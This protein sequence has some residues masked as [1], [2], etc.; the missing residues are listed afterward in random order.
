MKHGLLAGAFVAMSA[1]SQA[2]EFDVIAHRGA[3][4]YLPEHT[5]EAA[6]LAHAQGPA[7]IEQDVVLTKD[8]IP[9]VLHDIHLE[10]VTNVESV[11]PGRAREDKRYYAIDFTLDELKQLL[12]HERANADGTQV[13]PNRYQGTASFNIATLEEHIELISQ[14]NRITGKDIGFY[15]EVKSPAWHRSEGQDISVIVLETLRKYGLDDAHANIYVQCF[16]HDEL[17]RIRNDLG[18]KLKLVQLMGENDWGESPTDYDWLRTSEG[19]TSIKDVAQGIGPWFPQLVDMQAFAK[20]KLEPQPWYL[21]AK[22]M[23]LAVHPYTFRIDALPQG[24]ESIQLLDV[25]VK[26]LKV[27]GLFTDQVP[28]VMA[29][30][31]K[32]K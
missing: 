23:G 17:K 18:A 2:A 24:M 30:L 19:L 6:S 28:P 12:V 26:H 14:L 27:E 8:G 32:D 13:F 31:E 5:L 16:D 22:Q 4:G 1:L 21:N 25:L 7:F 11:F 9:V 10:T 20:G 3:S 29:Y 15:P